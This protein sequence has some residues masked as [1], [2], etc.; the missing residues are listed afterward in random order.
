MENSGN[1]KDLGQAI[2]V[3]NFHLINV[4]ILQSCFKHDSSFDML[5][6]HKLIISQF[7]KVNLT[8]FSVF[9]VFV[10]AETGKKKR[11]KKNDTNL[12]FW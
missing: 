10:K 7:Q 8:S 3:Q 2:N 5:P 6:M 11:K 12:S 1:W 4:D 9:W